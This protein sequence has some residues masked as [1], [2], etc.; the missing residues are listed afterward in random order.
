MEISTVI[1]SSQS[2]ETTQMNGAKINSLDAGGWSIQT[3]YS[4]K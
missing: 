4:E 1:L 2:L 3:N